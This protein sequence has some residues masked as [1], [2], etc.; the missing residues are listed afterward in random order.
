MAATPTGTIDP[1]L[2]KRPLSAYTVFT[3]EF[4]NSLDVD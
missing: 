4:I 1:A 3:S 2:K